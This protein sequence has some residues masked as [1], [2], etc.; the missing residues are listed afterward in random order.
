MDNPDNLDVDP[1]VG[2]D[3]TDQSKGKP[4]GGD[5][6]P[7]TWQTAIKEDGT[8]SDNWQDVLPESLRAPGLGKFTRPDMLVQSYQHMEKMQGA[9]AERKVLIPNEKT[10]AEERDSFY[11]KLG[12]PDK[13]DGYKFEIPKMPEGH[14]YDKALEGQFRAWAHEA[15]LTQPQA[16]TI[17]QKYNE[18]G[19]GKIKQ[20]Q[21][22]VEQEKTQAITA[23]QREWGNAYP[24]KLDKANAVIRKFDPDGKVQDSG[25]GNHPDVVKMM[26]AIGD[27]ITED[28]AL[29]GLPKRQT[30]SDLEDEIKKIEQSPE[31]SHRDDHIRLPVVERRM[32][33]RQQIFAAQD[34]R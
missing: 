7:M 32:R 6:P 34:G 28:K 12:R 29:G 15:G 26:S 21:E 2:G 13:P 17:M 3:L 24:E 27:L 19:L 16:A 4:G 8:F 33:L 10:T 22:L 1:D 11:R 30:I 5:P 31:F 9:D 25:F 14:E 18:A 20:F 23:L